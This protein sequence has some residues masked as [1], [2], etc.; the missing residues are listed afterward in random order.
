MPL[1]RVA[2]FAKFAVDIRQTIRQSSRFSSAKLSWR[3]GDERL[4]G[5]GSRP[6]LAMPYVT[7]AVVTSLSRPPAA[8]VIGAGDVPGLSGVVGAGDRGTKRWRHPLLLPEDAIPAD[9]ASFKHT[10]T[11]GGPAPSVDFGSCAKAM[12]GGP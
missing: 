11:A 1:A 3:E 10:R 4:I 8:D 12:K 9:L 5:R 2:L 6:L 7:M